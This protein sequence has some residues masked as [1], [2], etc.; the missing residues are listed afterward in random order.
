M[1]SIHSIVKINFSRHSV[2]LHNALSK[3]RH[4]FIDAIGALNQNRSLYLVS[5]QVLYFCKKK[6]Q[7]K[8]KQ[9]KKQQ[10]K[11]KQKTTKKKEKKRNTS[12][13]MPLHYNPP[14]RKNKKT[15]QKKT[16]QKKQEAE[17]CLCQV[18]LCTCSPVSNGT[19]ALYVS[20]M[21]KIKYKNSPSLRTKR[22]QNWVTVRYV[23]LKLTF[24]QQSGHQRINT[25][26][27]KR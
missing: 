13:F 18:I 26:K 8:Q 23:L 19:A 6:Q 3:W 22:V 25:G 4:I 12:Y 9:K 20:N 11:N 21:D 1:K 10:Q 2:H 7:K 27:V 16:P 17:R 5:W 24:Q 15:K 14:P